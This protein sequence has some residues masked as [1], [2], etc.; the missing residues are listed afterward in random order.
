[1]TNPKAA[2]L[3]PCP[4]CKS[5][6]IVNVVDDGLHWVHCRV[7]DATGPSNTRYSDE[8]SADWNT[9]SHTQ[10]EDVGDGNHS[11]LP[12]LLRGLIARVGVYEKKHEPLI[13]EYT[14]YIRDCLKAESAPQPPK[15]G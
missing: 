10:K 5:H 7:C 3:L 1:M 11:N 2:T 6:N 12:G 9:R 15:E 4:F 13:E 8:S 14:K